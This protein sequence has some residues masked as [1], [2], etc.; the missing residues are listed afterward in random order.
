MDSEYSFE[1]VQQ[2]LDEGMNE[3]AENMLMALQTDPD[4]GRWHYLMSK[5]YMNKGWLEYANENAGKAVEYD[6]ENSEYTSYL[7]SINSTRKQEY[8]KSMPK[9]AVGCCADGLNCI[10]C[11]SSCSD[12]LGGL[13]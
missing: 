1:R 9:R 3:E 2:L 11:C 7:D 5:V 6:S 8:K 4:K 13:A 12:C 10:K